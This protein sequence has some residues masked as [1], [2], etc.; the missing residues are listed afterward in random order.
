MCGSGAACLRMFI[1]LLS[2]CVVPYN[3]TFIL[4]EIPAMYKMTRLNHIVK[5]TG[6]N[7]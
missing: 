7:T 6:M 4:P 5:Q 3:L 1:S 2:R